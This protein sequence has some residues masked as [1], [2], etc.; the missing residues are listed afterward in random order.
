LGQVANESIKDYP[1][2]VLLTSFQAT[3]EQFMMVETGDG[4]DN[5]QDYTRLVFSKLSPHIAQS[6]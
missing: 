2:E 1:D 6:F 5:Y 3:F 4:L